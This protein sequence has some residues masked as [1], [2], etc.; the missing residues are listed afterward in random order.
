MTLPA[1]LRKCF[2]LLALRGAQLE[3]VSLRAQLEGT[4]LQLRQ[5]EGRIQGMEVSHLQETDALRHMV[6]WFAVQGPHRQQVF[7][8]L[9]ESSLPQRE[10]SGP[11]PKLHMSARNLARQMTA[12]FFQDLVSKT[13]SGEETPEFYSGQEKKA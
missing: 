13:V 5:M 9:P 3:I 1:W 11:P 7:G 10:P 8:T 4:T 6:D 12:E 2:P